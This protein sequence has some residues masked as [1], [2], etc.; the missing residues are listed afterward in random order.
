[1]QRIHREHRVTGGHQC[2]HSRA[3][4]GLDSDR[5]L[6]LVGVTGLV[7][8]QRMQPRE[9]GRSFRQPALAQS[10]SG[11]IYQFDIV[12]VFGT[13]RRSGITPGPF[14]KNWSSLGPG[15]QAPA[16]SADP[17]VVAEDDLGRVTCH[18]L[19]FAGMTKMRGPVCGCAP[20]SAPPP[21]PFRHQSRSRSTA[22]NQL[23]LPG[24]G[25]AFNWVRHA[26]PPPA[27]R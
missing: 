9:R 4:V 20:A 21:S 27:P 19:W 2:R 16:L 25:R 5:H 26:E 17:P 22:G 15:L 8:D 13:E 3:A 1:M 12:V 10:V 14:L 18:Q 24:A 7:S 6:G 23:H 11:C